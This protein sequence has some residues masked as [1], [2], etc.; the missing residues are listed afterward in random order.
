MRNATLYL[1][2]RDGGCYVKIHH[3]RA[4]WENEVH[5][6]ERWAPAFGEHAPRLLAVR[7]EEPLALVISSLPGQ[8]LETHPL[9]LALEQQVWHD[10]GRAL[11][12]LHSLGVGQ[13]FGRCHRDGSPLGPVVSD[14]CT[15]LTQEMDGWLSRD[16]GGKYLSQDD[17]AVVESARHL[18]PAFAGER[19]SPCHR[20]YC[21]ANWLV[22]QAGAWTGVIDFEFAYWDVWTADFARD[23]FWNWISR[24]SLP[25]AFLAGYGRTITSREEQ[26]V[27]V[28]RALF[29]LAAVVWGEENDYHVFAEEGRLALKALGKIM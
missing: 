21:P 28:G 17:R 19:P 7:D 20:D 1:S 2:T 3:D 4:G 14:A 24:P 25:E 18:L 22:S 5:A 15:F 11:T 27:L 16:E 6:Y 29:A 8:A 12:A 10:A 26:Q 13:S 23:P 9:E